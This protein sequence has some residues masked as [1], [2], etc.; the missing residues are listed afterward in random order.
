MDGEQ[1]WSVMFWLLIFFQK[2][3]QIIVKWESIG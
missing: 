1:I 3:K 2:K